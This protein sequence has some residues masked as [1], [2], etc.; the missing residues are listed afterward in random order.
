MVGRIN[1][2]D[3]AKPLCD[4]KFP[5]S[6]ESIVTRLGEEGVVLPLDPPPEGPFGRR[7]TRIALPARWSRGLGANDR[8]QTRPEG[9]ELIVSVGEQRFRYSNAGLERA[10]RC[11]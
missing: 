8:V 5:S 7:I 3:R 1:A 4:L 6:D 11:R 2:L 10:D 9:G